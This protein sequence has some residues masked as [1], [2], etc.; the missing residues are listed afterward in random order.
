MGVRLDSII[1]AGAGI[2]GDDATIK[3]KTAIFSRSHSDAGVN[4]SA[5]CPDDFEEPFEIEKD[6]C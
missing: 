6:N 3:G 4:W 1:H 5:V 2:L